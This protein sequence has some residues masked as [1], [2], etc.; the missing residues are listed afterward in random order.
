MV[1]QLNQQKEEPHFINSLE[2]CKIGSSSFFAHKKIFEDNLYFDENLHACEDYD[3]WLRILLKY[4]IHLINEELINKYAGHENQLS[5]SS[6][7]IDTYRI[8]ALEKHLDSKYKKEV[9]E[10]LIK[11]TTILLKGAKK[12][13]N[14]I[15]LDKYGKKLKNYE[16]LI[17][18]NTQ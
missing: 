5:F 10:E 3:L 8:S 14:T 11:K 6:K 18:P 16:A 12:H 2:L 4:K 1:K 13:Q 7:L 17:N 15:V 9:I